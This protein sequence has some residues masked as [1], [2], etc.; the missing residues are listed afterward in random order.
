MATTN[1]TFK[2]TKRIKVILLIISLAGL[3]AYLFCNRLPCVCGKIFNNAKCKEDHYIEGKVFID[4]CDG[5]IR[6]SFVRNIRVKCNEF[7]VDPTHPDAQKYRD[8]LTARCFKKVKICDCTPAFELWA[9]PDGHPIDAG[10]VASNTMLGRPYGATP[11]GLMPNL[12]INLNPG[13]ELKDPNNLDSFNSTSILC[14]LNIPQQNGMIIA[15]VDTGID[16]ITDPNLNWLHAFNWDKYHAS[17]RCIYNTSNFGINILKQKI[18]PID[19]LGHGTAVNGVSSGASLPNYKDLYLDLSFLNVGIFDANSNS[20]TL[21]N[22]LCGLNYSIHQNAK[23]INISWGFDFNPKD[24]FLKQCVEKTITDIITSAP[25]ILFIAGLGNDSVSISSTRSFYP[26]CLAAN[27]DN[28]MAI[29]SLSWNSQ[30]LAGFSNYAIKEIMTLSMKGDRILSTYPDYLLQF[31]PGPVIGQ[32]K[33]VSGTSFSTPL[34][35]RVAA[36]FWIRNNSLT[37]AQVKKHFINYLDPIAVQSNL[38]PGLTIRTLNIN[39]ISGLVCS[40]PI[41]DPLILY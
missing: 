13:P 16:T 1:Q 35:S 33:M 28:L 2:L 21:F 37:P 20:C 36:S 17:D 23:I 24:E 14:N 41:L 11:G 4:K 5:A 30:D 22:A 38:H 18:E 15:I 7:I 27:I 29:G 26:A 12:V 8:S 34:V 3:A 25:H 39:Q 10:T 40:P 31:N 6:D 32:R 19:S 9:N